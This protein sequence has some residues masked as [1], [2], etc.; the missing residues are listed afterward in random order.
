MSPEPLF[1]SGGAEVRSLG[2]WSA[3]RANGCEQNRP[4]PK[5][6]VRRVAFS[7]PRNCTLRER[8]ASVPTKGSVGHLA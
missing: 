4:V 5:P 2:P 6:R 3:P 8:T 1:V 7:L